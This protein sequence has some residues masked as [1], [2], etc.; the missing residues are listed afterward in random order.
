MVGSYVDAS[1]F[2]SQHLR[3]FYHMLLLNGTTLSRN[4]FMPS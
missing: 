3:K 4:S 1:Y 2:F